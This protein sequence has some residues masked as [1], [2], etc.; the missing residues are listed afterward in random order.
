MQDTSSESLEIQLLG[1]TS[2]LC[3]QTMFKNLIPKE[4]TI[5][6]NIISAFFE[7]DNDPFCEYCVYFD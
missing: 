6:S 4:N 7:N 2:G 1:P 3:L 5:C